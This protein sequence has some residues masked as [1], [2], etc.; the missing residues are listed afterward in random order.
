MPFPV[1]FFKSRGLNSYT[2]DGK[3]A[4][5]TVEVRGAD[6]ST[7][8]VQVVRAGSRVLRRRPVVT[9]ATLIVEPA[10]PVATPLRQPLAAQTS[11]GGGAC[12]VDCVVEEGEFA[13]GDFTGG[14]TPAA[15]AD[16][17]GSVGGW[18]GGVS[19]GRCARFRAAVLSSHGS[20]PVVKIAVLSSCS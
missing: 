10:A 13:C 11:V 16:G 12:T 9:D 4:D 5:L 18:S 1:L 15:W 17:D 3:P 6:A 8:E 19:T 14:E 7:T 20:A 2:A